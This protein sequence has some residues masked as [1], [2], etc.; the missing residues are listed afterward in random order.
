MSVLSLTDPISLMKT[1]GPDPVRMGSA[2]R[3]LMLA[4]TEFIGDIGAGMERQLQQARVLNG[5]RLDTLDTVDVEEMVLVVI[6]DVPFHL[7]R[8]HAAVRLR[9]IDDGQIQIG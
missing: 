6:R 3:S 2:S 8:A 9:H 5:F 4:T 1:V 7:R